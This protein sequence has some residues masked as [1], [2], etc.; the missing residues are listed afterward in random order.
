MLF[1]EVGVLGMVIFGGICFLKVEGW[2]GF[3]GM[4]VF[5]G[6][7]FE[8]RGEWEGERVVQEKFK[9]S[10]GSFGLEGFV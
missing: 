10:W 3:W 8:T 4:L 7:C 6:I 1:E 2:G 5:D 9:R